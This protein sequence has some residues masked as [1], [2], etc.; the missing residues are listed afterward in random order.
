MEIIKRMSNVSFFFGLF[1]CFMGFIH[2]LG[3]SNHE[4]LRL[5]VF[6]GF[7]FIGL[8]GLLSNFAEPKTGQLKGREENN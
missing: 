2:V 8:G 3:F 6:F 7:L 1:L 5:S 4:I